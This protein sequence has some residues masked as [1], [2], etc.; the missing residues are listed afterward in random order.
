[1]T[2]P[3]NQAS[4]A[5]STPLFTVV[6]GNPSE[7]EVAALSA[8]LAQLSANARK[9]AAGNS[10]VDA[11]GERNLWGRATDR[12]EPLK[13]FNPSAFRNVRYY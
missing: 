1:M 2:T 13:Q 9:A 6:K 8:A 10:T 11:T 5:H 3:N 4:Q 7:E 12:F